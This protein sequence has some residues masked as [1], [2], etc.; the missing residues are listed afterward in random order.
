M[1][2]ISL[3][4]IILPSSSSVVCNF[5]SGVAG[6]GE[7]VCVVCKQLFLEYNLA[8]EAETFLRGQP[9]PDTAAAKA[10][11]KPAAKAKPPLPEDHPAI[12]ANEAIIKRLEAAFAAS[13]PSAQPRKPGKR[14]RDAAWCCLASRLIGLQRAATS[15]ND[16]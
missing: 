4:I 5:C 15:C 2:Y 11:V 13:A 1:H 12:L 10:Q 7:I 6:R 9:A 3:N 8:K 14:A 16:M